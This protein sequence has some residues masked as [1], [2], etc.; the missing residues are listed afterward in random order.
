V[1]LAALLLASAALA[2]GRSKAQAVPVQLNDGKVGLEFRVAEAKRLGSGKPDGA[3]IATL[4]AGLD[5]KSEVL[6]DA[7]LASLQKLHAGPALVKQATERSGSVEQRLAALRGLRTLK[8]VEAA[9][10][11]AQAL[12][13]PD[14][15]VRAAAGQLFC[16]FGAEQAQPQLIAALADPVSDVRYFAVVA[17]GGIKSPKAAEAL[18]GLAKTEKD[19]VVQDALAQAQRAKN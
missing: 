10:E 2:G 4:L 5:V 9:V 18:A 16:V 14:A 15:K 13:D 7:I 1:G 19:P 8:P 6:R 17:L 12:S 3:T 11:L